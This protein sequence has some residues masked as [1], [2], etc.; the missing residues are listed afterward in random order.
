MDGDEVRKWRRQHP[1]EVEAMRHEL[2]EENS[3]STDDIIDELDRIA[4]ESKLAV[5]AVAFPDGRAAVIPS[6]IPNRLEALE[7][8]LD[9]DKDSSVV[10]YIWIDGSGEY[11]ASIHSL[12][13][14]RGNEDM[15]IAIDASESEDIIKNAADVLEI[16][17]LR[18]MRAGGQG[19]KVYHLGLCSTP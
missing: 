18:H 19:G 17:Q 1:D 3:T 9:Q 8:I 5:V 11:H 4:V 6:D 13:R 7:G 2:E 10:G 12:W 14:W 15:G 16:I